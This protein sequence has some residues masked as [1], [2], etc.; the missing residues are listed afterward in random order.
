MISMADIITDFIN[1]IIS[2]IPLIAI[3]IGIIFFILW[4]YRRSKKETPY[5]IIRLEKEVK[6]DMKDVFNLTKETIGYG[7]TLYIGSRNVGFILKSIIIPQYKTLDET[8]NNAKKHLDKVEKKDDR[9]EFASKYFYSKDYDN[10][11]VGEIKALTEKLEEKPKEQTNAGKVLNFVYGFE[12]CGRGF[13][14]RLL[15]NLG[16]GVDFFLIDESLIEEHETSF[17]VSWQSKPTKTLGVWIV[18][19]AGLQEIEEIAYK[20]KHSQDLE[21]LINVI[22]RSIYL[23]DLD[24]AKQKATFDDMEEV[25]REKR[26]EQLEQIK[27]A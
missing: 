13:I 22:P 26:K 27:K 21:Q 11:T 8:L 19:N 16:L 10:L 9:L 23:S 4:L 7:K 18:S 14:K 24:H 1:A 25:I 12:T 3:A 17:N 15:A 5:E 20:I 2:N 6:K